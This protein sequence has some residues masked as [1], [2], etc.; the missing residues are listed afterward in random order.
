MKPLELCK[1]RWY[2]CL[3]GIAVKLKRSK[4]AQCK[5]PRRKTPI[6]RKLTVFPK[7]SKN[8][9]FR[10]ISPGSYLSTLRKNH[11]NPRPTLKYLE[12]CQ[13]RCYECLIGI[14]VKLKHSRFPLCKKP[15]RNTPIRRELTVFPKQSKHR[16]FRPMCLGSYLSTLRKYR[17]NPKP[18]FKPL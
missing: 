18:N 14:A 10:P 12:L 16:R 13:C 3:T 2:V 6:R 1:N 4:F 8:R 17:P 7:Q 15:R 9:K 5:K 11:S